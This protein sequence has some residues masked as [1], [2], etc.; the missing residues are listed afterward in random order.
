MHEFSFLVDWNT[1]Y[2]YFIYVRKDKILQ[3]ILGWFRKSVVTVNN[4]VKRNQTA[5]FPF[6]IWTC[7]IKKCVVSKQLLHYQGQNTMLF[8]PFSTDFSIVRFDNHGLFFCLVYCYK[9]NSFV[10]ASNKY[11]FVSRKQGKIYKNNVVEAQVSRLFCD[12]PFFKI[13]S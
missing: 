13:Q 6:K 1:M 7:M 9:Q 8:S 12:T 10:C 3:I 4:N 2:M 11:V 5:L